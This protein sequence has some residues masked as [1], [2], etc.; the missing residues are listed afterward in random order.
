M[1]AHAKKLDVTTTDC[2]IVS[3]SITGHKAALSFSALAETSEG[4]LDRSII[5]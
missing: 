3:S 2:G 5:P 1:N 4:I